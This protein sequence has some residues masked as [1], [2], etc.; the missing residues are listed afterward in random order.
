VYEEIS[1]G[2]PREFIVIGGMMFADL[3]YEF[4]WMNLRD[5]YVGFTGYTNACPEKVEI[6]TIPRTRKSVCWIK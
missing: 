3:G 2:A 4:P 5:I 6:T 1:V